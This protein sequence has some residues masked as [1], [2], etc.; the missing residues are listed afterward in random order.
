MTEAQKRRDLGRPES[1]SDEKSTLLAFLNHVREAV[2]AKVQGFDV[3]MSSTRTS[4]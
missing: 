2:A 4:A 1:N 3:P